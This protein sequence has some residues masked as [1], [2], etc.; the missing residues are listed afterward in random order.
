M[1]VVGPLGWSQPYIYHHEV[2]HLR[3]ARREAREGIQRIQ[4]DIEIL[5]SL[6]P[7]LD[8]VISPPLRRNILEREQ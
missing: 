4:D 1:A 2:I 3:A 8:G 7:D 5:R 6:H